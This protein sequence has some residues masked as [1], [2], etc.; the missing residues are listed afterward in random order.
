MLLPAWRSNLHR[1]HTVVA[2]VGQFFCGGGRSNTKSSFVVAR[3]R[4]DEVVASALEA[5]P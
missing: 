3:K 5:G 1:I 4:R 2:V